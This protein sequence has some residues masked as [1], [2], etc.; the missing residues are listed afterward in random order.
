M[1]QA[2]LGSLKLECSKIVA[3]L[4]ALWPVAKL[5]NPGLLV[6][7][8]LKRACEAQGFDRKA[9]QAAASHGLMALLCCRR[10]ATCSMG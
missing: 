2:M 6:V 5:L 4:E 10:F 9:V 7:S 1:M 3:H 8:P